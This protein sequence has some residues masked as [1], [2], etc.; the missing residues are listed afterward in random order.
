MSVRHISLRLRLVSENCRIVPIYT[1]FEILLWGGIREIFDSV[2]T[3]IP[4]YYNIINHKSH[5]P[6]NIII[7]TIFSS[8]HHY[9]N[10]CIT[11]INDISVSKGIS[12][13][14]YK[15][16]IIKSNTQITANHLL[17]NV[18]FSHLT[19]IVCIY[20]KQIFYLHLIFYYSYLIL[21]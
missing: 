14:Y 11:I 13:E 4:N 8:I 2:S 12:V 17:I 20:I 1:I 19:V 18:S 9:T 5:N 3:K 16:I 21:I 6:S 15:R 10:I 7:Y